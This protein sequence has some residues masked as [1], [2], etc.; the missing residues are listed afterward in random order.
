MHKANLQV[1][2]VAGQYVDEV[3]LLTTDNLRQTL[4]VF[5]GQ[6]VE[7]IVRQLVTQDIGTVLGTQNTDPYRRRG[8]DFAVEL[9]VFFET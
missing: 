5:V 3:N 6:H 1:G 4:A 8:D 2:I 7:I 9:L